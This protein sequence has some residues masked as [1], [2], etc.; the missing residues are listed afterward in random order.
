MT[1]VQLCRG[2]WRGDYIPYI[3]VMRSVWRTEA[4]ECPLHPSSFLSL[5]FKSSHSKQEKV[6]T[7]PLASLYT[8]HTL[9]L[10]AG[11]QKVYSQSLGLPKRLSTAEQQEWFPGSREDVSARTVVSSAEGHVCQDSNVLCCRTCLVIAIQSWAPAVQYSRWQ[12]A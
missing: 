4:L 1:C 2:I 3:P 10:V 11:A 8:D 7:M 12:E 5:L 9:G 6:D